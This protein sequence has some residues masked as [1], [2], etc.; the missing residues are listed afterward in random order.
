MDRI[1]FFPIEYTISSDQMLSN[2]YSYINFRKNFIC[3]TL[4]HIQLFKTFSF[5]KFE[6]KRNKKKTF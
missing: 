5:A 3:S 1:D 4:N 6:E 2:L